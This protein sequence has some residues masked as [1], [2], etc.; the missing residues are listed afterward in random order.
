MIILTEK[1]KVN[2]V[3]AA[4]LDFD[5]TLSTLRCGWEE[6]MGPRMVEFISGGKAD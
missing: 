1:P 2:T 3:K 4:V 6:V 5:G